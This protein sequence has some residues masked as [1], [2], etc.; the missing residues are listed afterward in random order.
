MAAPSDLAVWVRLLLIGAPVAFAVTGLLH[1]VSA[2]EPIAGSDFDRVSF[3]NRAGGSVCM[4]SPC[5]P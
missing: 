5:R 1:L 4:W 2:S 3:L